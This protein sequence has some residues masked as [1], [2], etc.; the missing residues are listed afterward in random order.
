MSEMKLWYETAN[1]LSFQLKNRLNSRVMRYVVWFEFREDDEEAARL[2][3]I[4]S[5]RGRRDDER[6]LR[7]MYDFS[8]GHAILV[9]RCSY[10]VRGFLIPDVNKV[11]LSSLNFTECLAH[12]VSYAMTAEKTSRR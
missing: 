8:T 2:W 6:T 9:K 10:D 1:E 7:V 11:P 4:V 12:L 5:R 3:Y